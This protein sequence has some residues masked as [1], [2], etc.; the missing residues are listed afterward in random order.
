MEKFIK[1]EWTPKDNHPGA[2]DLNRIESGIESAHNRID[3]ITGSLVNTETATNQKLEIATSLLV[4][5][6]KLGEGA[7]VADCVAKIK[8]IIDALNGK[9]EEQEGV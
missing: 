6:E 4:G 9:T 1:R 3:K 8:E 7:K 5:I 2:S